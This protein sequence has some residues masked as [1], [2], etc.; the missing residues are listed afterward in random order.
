[1]TALQKW[2]DEKHPLIILVAHMLAIF[3]CDFE[4]DFKEIKERRFL[5]TQY[6]LER[7]IPWFRQYYMPVTM[8]KVLNYIQT[9]ESQMNEVSNTNPELVV[10]ELQS[11]ASG[12]YDMDISNTLYD[13]DDQKFISSLIH[14]NEDEFQFFIFVMVPCLLFF[15]KSPYLL[16]KKAKSGNIDA[17]KKLIS[18][19][20]S[21]LHNPFIG[22]QIQRFRFTN[23]RIYRELLGIPFDRKSFNI[24]KKKL[25][26][27]LAGL[28]SLL[29]QIINELLEKQILEPLNE[30]QIREYFNAVSWDSKRKPEDDDLPPV[31]Q[32]DS[33]R[34]GIDRERTL[35]QKALSPDRNM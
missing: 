22:S 7:L 11:F 12:L 5:G 29:P 14:D 3:I 25:K 26:Y 23:K 24:S 31:E 8:Q 1:M 16:Y 13:K 15:K 17:L 19:D 34:R 2:T 20:P 6:K 9:T 33:F 35:W 4:N 30:K 32:R 10:Q 27:S 21:L 18:L 28:L